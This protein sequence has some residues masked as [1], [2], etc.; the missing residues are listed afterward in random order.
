MKDQILW[1]RFDE[2]NWYDYG[3]RFYDPGLDYLLAQ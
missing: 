1:T 3:A 2:T